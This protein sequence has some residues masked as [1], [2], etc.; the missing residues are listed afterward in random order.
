M[1]NFFSEKYKGL[2]P[3]TPGEQ[4]QDM[5]YVKLNTNESPF[6]PCEAVAKAAE[7]AAKKLQLY[8]DPDCKTL[9]RALAE[10]YDVAPE[11]I[12]LTNGSDEVLNFAFM[13][14][15]DADHPI[16]FPDI[17]YGFYPVFA[18]INRVPF[19][20]IPLRED[21]SID[22]ADYTNVGCNVVIAN[23]NAPT[24]LALRAEQIEQIAVTNPD[25]VV[26]IDE[27]Y[28]DFGAESA[29][30]LTKN[31][32]NLLVTQTFSKSR[33][34][35]GGRLGFGIADKALI[36][37]LN[38]VKYSTN[39]YNITRM[40]NEAALAV[41]QNDD[42]YMQNCNII[43]KNRAYLSDALQGLGFTVLPSLSNFIFVKSDRIGGEALYLGLKKRGV[44]VRHFT[45][46]RIKDYNRITIG[47]REQ[48]D[49][50][51]REIKQL[52]E[53]TI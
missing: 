44:L 15:C 30:L 25:H 9:T 11:N 16:T 8:P 39:P 40:T 21:F 41:L 50:L 43:Q 53:E 20:A 5:Q 35:A 14:F 48:L 33:S 34:F 28:V 31:Y 1:S 6:P 18:E 13:A 19:Q 27:A 37:D 47:S 12:I 51:L 10:R 45:A 38:T 32:P 49:I 42:F 46:E 36:A 52:L 22:P 23:P 2:T 7:G 26:I 4:P 3:Y 24:G 29:V 17:S